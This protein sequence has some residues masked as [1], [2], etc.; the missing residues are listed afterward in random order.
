MAGF[1]ARQQD[2]DIFLWVYPYISQSF[3]YI[4]YI[5]SFSHFFSVI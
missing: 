1:R 4:S 2:I 3:K 5:T